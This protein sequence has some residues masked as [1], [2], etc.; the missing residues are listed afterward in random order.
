MKK[1]LLL[2]F[3]CLFGALSGVKAWTSVVPNKGRSYYLHC[4]V[5]PNQF[6]GAS[7]TNT[8][9]YVTS[10]LNN[11]TPVTVEDINDITYAMSFYDGGTKYYLHQ[12]HGDIDW[13][14]SKSTMEVPG[15]VGGYAVRND[16]YTYWE[17]LSQK[18][19]HRYM[20]PDGSEGGISFGEVKDNNADPDYCWQF[21]SVY[22]MDSNTPDACASA[23]ES[24]YLSEANG[25][26]RVT[27]NAT[28]DA[29]LSDYFFAIVCA[30]YPG[31]MV[32]MA[33]GNASQQAGDKFSSSKSMWYSNSA[34]PEV[35]NSFLWMIEPNTT[36]NYEGY[37]FR[38]ASYPSLTIQTEWN[39][40]GWGMS[41]YAHTNDQANPC[42][43]NSYALIPSNGVYT[44]KTLANGGDNY[45]GLWT[46]SNDYINGQELAGNK[47]TAEQGKF[48]IYRKLK[49]NVDMTSRIINPSFETGAL[50]PWSAETRNDTGVKDQS[51]GTY[52]ITQGDPV[53]GQKLFNSWGGTAENSVSQTISLSKGTYRLSALLAGFNGET[54][55]LSAGGQ[56][57]NVVVEG[58][59]TYGYTV[60]VKFTLTETSNVTIKA[61]NTKSQQTSDAS[62]IKA[63]NFRLTYL[64]VMATEAD[65]TALQNAI[66]NAEDKTLGFET[67][68]YAPY[69]NVTVLNALA[70]A[71]A[72]DPSADNLQIDVQNAT[73]AIADE[74][75]AE[76]A[77]EV[78]NV[79]RWIYTDYQDNVDKQK[80]IGFTNGDGDVIR[81]SANYDPNTGLNQLDQKMCLN[82]NTD[83]KAAIYGETVGYTLPLKPYTVYKLTFSYAGWGDSSG[84]PT[85]KILNEDDSE[86][87]P[88]TLGS[89]TVQGNS[90]TVP[91]TSA[92][93]LFQTTTAGNYKVSFGKS[94]NRTA[95]GDI[96][97]K[98]LPSTITATIGA[99]G[100]TTFAS[101]Y[102]LDLTQANLPVGVKAYKA[103]SINSS[104]VHF[105]K[106]NQVVPANTGVLLEGTAGSHNIRVG[107][108]VE[109]ATGN[110]FLVN[111]S[112][113]VFSPEANTTYYAMVKNSN[114]MTFGKFDPSVVA[115]PNYKAYLKVSG[116][117]QARLTVMFDG[118]DP[119]AINAIEAAEA[120]DGAL[121]DGKYIIDNKVVIVKNGVKYSANGQKLN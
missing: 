102:P 10:N 110:L 57:S 114:P 30:N 120:E 9:Y 112:N 86:L 17:G 53:D 95:F 117:S 108:E 77:T 115:V 62:F 111:E 12:Y 121:K 26:E 98:K 74:N 91:W 27:D 34:N 1:N 79:I 20:W 43:W 64:G 5:H 71:K 76:N 70:D 75:W 92:T 60:S 93:I 41:W 42:Q 118:E 24:S 87:K 32:N 101:A 97:L 89:T 16:K 36:P 18:P 83:D 33:N 46:R 21:I 51:N 61:S 49:K 38:N 50:T 44:I 4:T 22:E 2:L 116:G 99:N 85:I 47:G 106:L 80:P 11:A 40:G 96:E 35:D 13:P 37:T 55:T 19:G 28:L 66:N 90:T 15:G 56:S 52:S 14:T 48:L 84:A 73:A 81:V 8:R 105:E 45:L 7:K 69:N 29:S 78:N 58:D 72:I 67:G 65:Y 6:W 39:T 109:E 31:L 107:S 68:E 3:A 25:W 82:I 94:G 100:Y 23:A 54:L 104:Y 88:V 119:T 63:D 59:K 113:D 103:T